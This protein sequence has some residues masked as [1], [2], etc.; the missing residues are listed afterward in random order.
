MAH[1]SFFREAVALDVESSTARELLCATANSLYGCARQHRLERLFVSPT[2]SDAIEAI[3]EEWLSFVEHTQP[4][5][6][7]ACSLLHYWFLY[8]SRAQ[9]HAYRAA[10]LKVFSF[11]YSISRLR[12]GG[13]CSESESLQDER[14]NED[15]AADVDIEDVDI[16]GVEDTPLSWEWDPLVCVDD[17]LGLVAQCVSRQRTTD[18][19]DALNLVSH[20][21]RLGPDSCKRRLLESDAFARVIDIFGDSS[22]DLTLRTTAVHALG[23]FVYNN[24]EAQQALARTNVLALL[25]QLVSEH[26][27]CHRVLNS[28]A[29][30]LQTCT[31]KFSAIRL[32]VC[33]TETL[34]TLLA[35]LATD[36]LRRFKQPPIDYRL[37]KIASIILHLADY[38]DD[39]QWAMILPPALSILGALQATR[40]D[41][42]LARFLDVVLEAA[43][44]DRFLATSIQLPATT[45]SRL[46]SVSV[47]PSSFRDKAASVLAQWRITAV[48]YKPCATPQ[49][50]LA[51]L[52]F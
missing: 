8:C 22:L 23:Y 15:A 44:R 5:H 6:T 27:N 10:L 26:P 20:S 14:S 24:D 45:A 28:S 17:L 2:P 16:D 39:D 12:D 38:L 37:P 7:L 35:S 48:P 40:R 43:K 49:P 32:R 51:E 47:L 31:C 13:D 30:L 9:R 29:L 46:G 11:A 19:I 3:V 34:A 36:S 50:E 41:I 18:A 1:A 33:R 21:L 42:P 52:L 4:T 25:D